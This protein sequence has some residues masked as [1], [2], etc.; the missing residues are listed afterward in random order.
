MSKSS[1]IAVD[2]TNG[3]DRTVSALI[4]GA[5]LVAAIAALVG[6]S[7]CV[8]PLMLAAVGVGG[9]WIAQLAIFVTYQWYILT[10]AVVLIANSWIVAFVR[11]SSKRAKII[12]AVSTALVAAAFVMPIYED[13]IAQQLFKI[14]RG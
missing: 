1:N 5:G 12:L 13:D 11:G 7:C 8:L 4:P 9:A 3:S 2:Q 10:I 14:M 6:A